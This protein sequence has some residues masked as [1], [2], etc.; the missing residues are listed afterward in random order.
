M[1]TK[2]PFSHKTTLI[3]HLHV[4]LIGRDLTILCRSP[5]RFGIY[6]EA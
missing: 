6:Q 1:C 3:E 4:P 5:M 2:E